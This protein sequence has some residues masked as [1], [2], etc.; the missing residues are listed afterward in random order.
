MKATYPSAVQQALL[1]MTPPIRLLIAG[2]C[3]PGKSLHLHNGRKIARYQVLHKLLPPYP[4]PP[5]HHT[6]NPEN[7]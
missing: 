4:L 1:V 3:K 5:H 7:R 2:L 6:Q